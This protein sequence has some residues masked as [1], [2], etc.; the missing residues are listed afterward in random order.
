MPQA[1]VAALWQRVATDNVRELSD[2]DGFRAEFLRHH[3]FGIAGIDY[4]KDV[5]P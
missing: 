4:A 2:L 5:N 3:G 1:E